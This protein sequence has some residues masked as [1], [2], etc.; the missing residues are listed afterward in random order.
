MLEIEPRSLPSPKRQRD[1][2]EESTQ[3][4]GRELL[5]ALRAEERGARVGFYDRLAEW[6]MRDEALKVQLFRFIDALP[7]LRSAE[8]VAAHLREYLMRPGLRL[9]PGAGTLLA[10]SA[11]SRPVAALLAW[12]ARTAT[13]QMARRFIAGA[14][15][16]ESREGVRHLVASPEPER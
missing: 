15:L 7:S 8:A 2:I 3:A 9:P 13:H 10:L 11:R 14:D 6:A 5:A 4:I 12:T 1:G 16:R